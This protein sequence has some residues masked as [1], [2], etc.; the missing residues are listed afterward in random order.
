MAHKDN[1]LSAHAE[2]VT[3]F[4]V[5]EVA[6]KALDRSNWTADQLEAYG[7]QLGEIGASRHIGGSETPS[8]DAPRIWA[9]ERIVREL[10]YY[11]EVAP[12]HADACDAYINMWYI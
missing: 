11:A 2:Y 10:R 9:Y 7:E 4:P 3:F 12:M 8:S 5:M 6:E 1:I